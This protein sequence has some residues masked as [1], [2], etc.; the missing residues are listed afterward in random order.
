[1]T[2]L[3]RRGF[4]QTAAAVAASGL[5]VPAVG[6]AVT[7]G[8]TGPVVISSANGI[9]ATK[10]AATMIRDGADTLDAVIAGVNRVEDAS[11]KSGFKLVGDV[12][13]EAVKEVAGAISPVPGGAGPMTITM[14]LHNT[15]RA[16]KLKNGLD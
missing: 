4:I 7:S 8:T 6:K 15:I 3:S 1:M 9:E 11:K 12:D 14:L 5:T 13:F 2:D 10:K 16:A